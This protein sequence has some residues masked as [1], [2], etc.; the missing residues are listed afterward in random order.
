MKE[1]KKGFTLIELM[2]VVAIIGILAAIAIPNFLR[3]QARSKQSEARQNLGAI[4]TAY[5][6]YFSDNNAYPA[7]VVIRDVNG[8]AYNCFAIADWEPK[9]Q[10]RYNY[11]CMG[12]SGTWNSTDQ[13]LDA[14]YRPTATS[15]QLDSCAET[16]SGGCSNTTAENGVNGSSFT[17]AACGNIDSDAANDCWS[18]SDSKAIINDCNDVRNDKNEGGCI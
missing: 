16:A 17:V 13:A 18:E 2:I 3:F 4:Y 6:A 10:V 5:A 14:K 12:H 11:D 1:K 7:D 9:G 8:V 15:A